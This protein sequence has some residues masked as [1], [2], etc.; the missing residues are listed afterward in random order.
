MFLNRQW[1]LRS[2]PHDGLSLDN[3]ELRESR[4]P[5]LPLG[6]GQIL[7][8][9]RV[10]ACTATLRNWLNAGGSSHRSIDLGSPM[11][12][13]VGARV[14]RSQHPRFPVGTELT[15]LGNWEDF[16]RLEPDASP[17]P[18]IPTPSGMSLVD[19][20]GIYGLNSCTAYFGLLRV[21]Q[22]RP[23]ET[24]VVSAAAGSVGSMVVQIA[25]ITGCRVIGIAGGSEKCRAVV[26]ELGADA[27]IDYKHEDVGARLAQ[28]C[29]KGVNVFF[30]NVGGDILSAVLDNIAVQG[31][32]A[33]C[34]QVAAYDAGI[35]AAGPRDMMNVIYRSVTIRGFVMSEFWNEADVARADLARWRAEGRLQQRVDLRHGFERLPGAFVGLFRGESQ[36]TLL[37]ESERS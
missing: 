10:F 4:E 16:T 21:A 1:L 12:G 14:V 15:L 3:F 17:T 11:R 31:R 13:P 30:D 34:G 2:R 7:V 23:G 22:P 29:P 24:V 37:V 32:I 20:M 26:S 35:P 36:G 27:A 25:K 5:E 28:L 9:N 19:A 33:L 8:Q 18:L 6:P